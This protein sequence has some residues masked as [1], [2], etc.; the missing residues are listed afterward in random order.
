MHM[1]FPP[2]TNCKHIGRTGHE[3]RDG[4]HLERLVDDVLGVTLRREKSRRFGVRICN[5]GL[6]PIVH[7]NGRT[8]CAA[9]L[10][11]ANMLCGLDSTAPPQWL[12]YLPGILGVAVAR[13]DAKALVAF[14]EAVPRPINAEHTLSLSRARSGVLSFEHPPE[15]AEDIVALHVKLHGRD[16]FVIVQSVHT[17]DK[18]KRPEIRSLRASTY[19]TVL[20]E[21]LVDLELHLLGHKHRK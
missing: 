1:Y 19:R 21:S 8:L 5:G 18:E 3:L 17:R 6:E 12:V 13:G 2:K 16:P 9:W 10:T 7:E 4:I 11:P 14:D 20:R 15:G